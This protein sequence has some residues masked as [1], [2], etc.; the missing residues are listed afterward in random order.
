MKHSR[1]KINYLYSS[2]IYLMLNKI[3]WTSS[4]WTIY[5]HTTNINNFLSSNG[6]KAIYIHTFFNI[7]CIPQFKGKWTN[8]ISIRNGQNQNSFKNTTSVYVYKIF[9]Y[10]HI[11]KFV[12]DI[13]KL[14]NYNNRCKN[15]KSI[16]QKYSLTQR[17]N[18]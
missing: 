7:K 11:N 3:R 16:V 17:G 12:V 15:Q 9:M 2:Y 14:Y 10:I 1:E 4:L 8:D 5:K 18:K 6:F 13:L